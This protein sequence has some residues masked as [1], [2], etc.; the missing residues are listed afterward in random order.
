MKEAMSILQ[1]LDLQG[2]W[3]DH[4][5][6]SPLVQ[7]CINTKSLAEGKLIHAHMIETTFRLDMVLETKLVI[8]YA[9]CGSLENARRVMNQMQ[10]R[11]AVS[12][13]SLIVASAK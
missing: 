8:M 6:Y 7:G 2:I 11:N 10:E 9:K 5:S 3:V 12:W 4:P 13:S 1:V